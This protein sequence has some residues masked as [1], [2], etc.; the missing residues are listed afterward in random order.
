MEKILLKRIGLNLSIVSI[1]IFTMLSGVVLYTESEL[2]IDELDDT[3]KQLEISYINS[4]Q[5]TETTKK[6][7]EEDYLNRA[8]AIDF[9][10]HNNPETNYNMSTL[11]KLK[12]LMS[13]ESI[14]IIANTGEIVLSSEEQSIGLNLKDHQE[15]EAFAK[16]ID[17]SDA[18]ANVVQ[19][20]AVSIT[21]KEPKTYIGV[22][23]SSKNYSV[24]QIG[25]DA[26]TFENLVAKNSI[27]SIV[28][29]TPT[30]WER[31]VFV[32]DSKSGEIEGISLN[33]EQEIHFDHAETKEEYL[34][35][36]N[37]SEKGKLIKINGAYKFLKTV[38][39]GD[40][41]IGAY[42]DAK[43]IFI[44]VFLQMMCLL[45]G[46]SITII[47]IFGVIKSLIKR[48]VLNDLY[49]IESTI[50]EL[51]AG[52][53]DVTFKTEHNTEFRYI[54]AILNEWKESYKYKSERMSR[55][56]SS[57]D[58]QV[59]LFECMYSINQNF[60]SN[61]IQTILGVNNDEWNEIIDS[62][63]GF[64]NY[65]QSLMS[66]SK[67]EIIALKNN[68]FISI[69]SFNKE[70]E[71]YGMIMDKTEDVKL[72]NKIQQ[73]LHVVQREAEVDPLTNLTN[74][75]RLEKTVNTSLG[76][77]PGKGIMIICDLDNF[78][79]VNDEMGHP[80]GDK[81]LKIFAQCL[82]SNFRENDVVAR[83]GGDEFVVFMRSNLPINV[84]AEKLQAILDN[85]RK[86]LSVY[87]ERFGLSTSI[88]AAYVDIA[89][90]S[91][92]DLY[93]CADVGLY[94]AKRLGKDGFYINEDNIR[95]M[96]ETCIQCTGDCKKRKL[97]G[98]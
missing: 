91:Y 7:F 93:L 16:L 44:A 36:L 80:E 13:V 46:I 60:Y 51:M 2:A 82:K 85:V 21:G 31:A 77:E 25:L 55:M 81:V 20:D 48:Y 10:L 78:K 49:A 6:I 63:K 98:L 40:T 59:A 87:H 27:S 89:K 95:C 1:V 15:S 32:I 90:N 94:I 14:H 92:E 17:S 11:K 34:S 50:K 33:N 47:C 66:H 58:S 52:N 3:I 5:D 86:E 56:I 37:S 67:D 79:S 68:K 83:I 43:K 53:K 62:P 30:V 61:N 76:N 65:L 4:Q 97:L 84:L 72:K 23:A 71:F 41:I 64:E 38:N 73:E 70:N 57:I 28:K 54:T 39:K 8:Y 18:N 12:E 35:I 24:I 19:L 75:A 9:I 22:K 42:V 26:S 69:V 88:G 74:R 96:R 45:I 29:N